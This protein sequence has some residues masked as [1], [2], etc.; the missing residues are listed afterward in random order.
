MFPDSS[1]NS[2]LNMFLSIK[3][4]R[5]LAA[6]TKKTVKE[7][8]L[9]KIKERCIGME[10]VSQSAARDRYWLAQKEQFLF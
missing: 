1:E 4:L 5:A 8:P 6:S 9:N 3:F 2:F 7:K 10:K